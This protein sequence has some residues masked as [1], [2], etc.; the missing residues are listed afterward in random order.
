M[1]ILIDIGHPAHVHYFRNFYSIMKSKG[2]EFLIIARDKEVSHQLLSEYN[3][4]F[5]SRGKGKKSALGK[6]FY[7]FSADRIIIKH[8]RKFKP[9]FFIGFASSYAAHAAKYLG[10]PSITFDDTEH[11]KLELLLYRPFTTF[12]LTPFCFKNSLGKKQIRFNSF[13]ELS[14]LH[15]NYYI[16]KSDVFNL[17][18]IEPTQKY[19]LLRFVS[20]N[21]SHDMGQVGLDIETKRSII[22]KL[23]VEYKVFIS[24]E[25]NLPEEF[26][27][28]RIKI[29]VHRMHDV[30]AFAHLFVGEG[31]TM[32]S[33]C[34]MLGIPA[35]YVNSLDAGTLQEQEKRGLITGFR[36]SQG[37]IDKIEEWL[38]NENLHS[39]M[40]ARRDNMLEE[41][42][43]PTKMLV[44]FIENYPESAKIMKDDPEYQM[45]FK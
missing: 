8:A 11:A 12:V 25:G 43:D 40:K 7:I 31:A 28:Y 18:G 23:K 20:W 27:Q 6:L 35:I 38:S 19:V 16:P 41:M 45:R 29:P 22:K 26:E 1:K 42:I 10:K 13:M 14:Y 39:E 21:A 5:V 34:A 37:V 3:L 9:D 36:N 24:A 15:P 32:A 30:L 4:P 33:E 44:W 2:H 17:L